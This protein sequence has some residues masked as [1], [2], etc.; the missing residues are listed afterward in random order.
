MTKLQQFFQKHVDIIKQSN[1]C[2]EECG[3]RLIGD[4]SEVAHILPKSFFK[5]ICTEDLNVLYLCSWKRG[6]NCHAEFDNG[7]NE[8]IKE[9]LIYPKVKKRFQELE[10]ILTEKI[11]YKTYER[12]DG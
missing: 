6:K 2:C 1:L 5:S 11:N 9:M 3:Q 10:D 12:F 7:S 4:F 8:K